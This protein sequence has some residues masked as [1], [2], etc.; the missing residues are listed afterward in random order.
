MKQVIVI[1]VALYGTAHADDKVCKFDKNSMTVT[2][3]A[4]LVVRLENPP[5]TKV[6]LGVDGIGGFNRELVW[7]PTVGDGLQHELLLPGGK[8]RLMA[9]AD[10]DRVQTSQTIATTSLRFYTV[11]KP[12]DVEKSTTT[13]GKWFAAEQTAWGKDSAVM[14]MASRIR[15]L[16]ITSG[17]EPGFVPYPTEES[18]QPKDGFVMNQHNPRLV[19]VCDDGRVELGALQ[20]NTKELQAGS[21]ARGFLDQAAP[22]VVTDTLALIAEIAVERAKSGAMTLVRERVIDPICDDL[23]LHRLHLGD[24]GELAFP[25]TCSMLRTIN[26]EDLLSSGRGLIEAA[27]DDVRTILLPRVIARLDLPPLARDL[28][29]LAMRVGNE[30][31]EGNQSAALDLI[32]AQVD[33][34]LG[35]NHFAEV[36]Q[37][38]I[39][40]VLDGLTSADKRG[41]LIKRA[42]ERL[43]P[44]DPGAW[45]SKYVATEEQRQLATSLRLDKVADCAREKDTASVFIPSDRGKCIEGLVKMWAATDDWR[46]GLILKFLPTD[47]EQLELIEAA[48]SVLQTTRYDEWLKKNVAS[49]VEKLRKDVNQ[50]TLRGVCAMR[51]AVGVLKWCSGRDKCTANDIAMAMEKPENLFTQPPNDS[52]E[53]LCWEP[54]PGPPAPAGTVQEKRLILPTVRGPYVELAA[55][56]IAFLT[57]PAKGEERERVLAVLSWI[58]DVAKVVESKDVDVSLVQRLQEIVGLFAKRDYV[59]ALTQTVSLSLER[60]ECKKDTEAEQCLPRSLQKAIKLLGSIASYVQVYEE[61]KDKDAAE[62]KSVRKKAIENLI[63]STTDRSER[64][65]D[66]IYSFGIPV[67]LSTGF[68]W[69]PETSVITNQNKFPRLYE[70]DKAFA[71]RLPLAVAMQRLPGPRH[72]GWHAALTFADLGNFVR[73]EANSKDDDIAW[74]DFVQIGL[75]GGVTFGNGQHMLI[76]AADV[77]WS[78]GLYERDVTVMHTDGTNEVLHRSGALFAGITLAYYVPLFDLN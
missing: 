63:D 75:Q 61:T 46:K 19:L 13:E 44:T 57:P 36:K 24:Q 42:F 67:G 12:A 54:K 31:L 74:K 48:R 49:F 18:T 11:D 5:R 59:R 29:K 33:R 60:T 70:H 40:E 3:A 28:A 25:R 23:D 58:F 56:A 53:S 47:D 62:A 76:I 35:A 7:D 10:D 4:N 2:G 15:T 51:V 32:V 41:E 72:V 26:V 1:L 30:M 27:R 9:F 77:S 37:R 55:R 16:V 69:T 68:R 64:G 21:V 52:V 45:L 34:Q 65:G 66:R 17:K 38:F 43:L 73:G 50:D 20:L 6:V 8:Y 71:W 22:T 14:I 78:P 39:T